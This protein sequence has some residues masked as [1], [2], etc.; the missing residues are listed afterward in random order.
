MAASFLR[1]S[2]SRLA[3]A[4]ALC[5]ACACAAYAAGLDR[6]FLISAVLA[7]VAGLAVLMLLRPPAPEPA[8]EP[9]GAGQRQG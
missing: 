2:S 6:I 4:L 3:L 8:A 7:A 5:A 1:P 9:V